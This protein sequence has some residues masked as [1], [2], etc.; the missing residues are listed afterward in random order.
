MLK[1]FNKFCNLQLIN[2]LLL[3][4][5]GFLILCWIYKLMSLGDLTNLSRNYFSSS[6]PQPMP[7]F[8]TFS[9]LYYY[10]QI[11][12]TVSI[13]ILLPFLLNIYK[14]ITSWKRVI[15]E[16]LL[17]LYFPYVPVLISLVVP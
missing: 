16:K 15:Q 5:G 10:I 17:Y 4:A 1:F 2:T 13:S 11:L 12:V 9:I 3:L 14:N 7:N 8:D 6:F